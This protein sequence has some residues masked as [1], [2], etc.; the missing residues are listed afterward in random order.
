MW[1]GGNKLAIA[2]TVTPFPHPAHRTG[3]ADFPHPALG[4]DIIPLHT[5]GHPQFTR[6]TAQGSCFPAVHRSSGLNST[7]NATTWVVIRFPEV[8]Q[9]LPSL[10]HAAPCAAPAH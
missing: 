4:Q 2:N 1:R 7:A 8:I 5:K 6:P 10:Q 9:V 3:H